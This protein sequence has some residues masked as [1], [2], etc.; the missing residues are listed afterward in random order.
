M[1]EIIK[2][3]INFFPP[4]LLLLRMR[5]SHRQKMTKTLT[6][7]EE[8][9]E[10]RRRTSGA[11]TTRRTQNL[12]RGTIRPRRR[13]RRKMMSSTTTTTDSNSCR[14]TRTCHQLQHRQHP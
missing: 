10:S 14:T 8:S 4:K 13:M 11:T 1:L 7:G 12:A 2:W 9:T 6:R 5:Y 3:Q